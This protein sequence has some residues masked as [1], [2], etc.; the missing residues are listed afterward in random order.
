MKP[1]LAV[2]CLAACS[3]FTADAAVAEDWPVF[4]QNNRRSAVTA[5]QLKLPLGAVWTRTSTHPPQRAWPPPAGQDVY[6][7]RRNLQATRASDTAF[8]PVVAGGK[9]YYGSSA[10]DTLYCVDAASGAT[11]WTFTTEGPIRLAP[12]VAGGKV[13]VG[14][15]DGR[16]TCLDAATGRLVWKVRGGPEDHRLPGNGRIISRWPVRCGML[17]ADDIVYFGAGVFPSQG[18]Y[19][20]AVKAGTGETIW[21][22]KIGTTIEGHLLA[23]DKE[24]YVL[25]GRVGAELYNRATGKRLAGLPASGS[26]FA[27]LA[28]GQFASG[29]SEAG[30]ITRLD[31]RTRK[32]VNVGGR[33]MLLHGGKVYVHAPGSLRQ[34]GGWRVKSGD[35][36]SLAMAGGVLIAGGANEVAAYNA[37]DG[38]RLWAGKADGNVHGLAVA[39]GQL[40][41]STDKGAIHCFGAGGKP[42]KT[43]SDIKKI[44]APYPDDELGKQYALAADAI[45]KQAKVAKGYCLVLDCGEGR[46]AYELA[47]RTKWRI[48]GVE[49]DPK[50]V[51]RARGLLRRAGVYGGRVVVHHLPPGELPYQKYFANVITSDAFVREGRVPSVSAAMIHRVLRPDGGTLVLPGPP[52]THRPMQGSRA[53]R[54]TREPAVSNLVSKWLTSDVRRGAALKLQFVVVGVNPQMIAAICRRPRLPGS[55]EWT[56][57]Y[58]NTANTACSNDDDGR[59]PLALQWFGR[60]GPRR[61]V[62]RHNRTTSPVTSAGRMFV[63]GL[64]HIVAAD[65]Y[66]GTILWRRDVPDSI[67]LAVSKDCGSLA[68]TP[69]T[70]YLASGARCIGLDAETGEQ[71]TTMDVP[72]RMPKVVFDW[73]Y[74][75]CSGDQLFG[76]A[77]VRLPARRVQTNSSWT[78]GYLDRSEIG[79]S[80]ALFSFDR[81][82]GQQQWAYTPKTGVIVN[83][84]IA[85]AEGR[86]YFVESIN[87]ET[88]KAPRDRIPLAALLGKGADVVAVDARTGRTVWRTSV[89]LTA[90]QHT[91]FLAHA[92]GTLVISGSKNAGGGKMRYDL[93]ALDAATGKQRWATTPEMNGRTGG[94]HGEQDQHPAIVG[95][96]IYYKT[97]AVDLKT[98]QRVTAWKPQGGGCSTVTASAHSMFFRSGNPIITDLATGKAQRMTIASRPGC[99]INIIPA[100]GLVLVPEASSGCT[101][102]YPIQTSLAMARVSC[103][104]PKIETKSLSAETAAVTITHSPNDVVIRYTTDGSL[105]TTKAAVYERP[106]ELAY[107]VTVRA[108]AFAADGEKSVAVE[109]ALKPPKTKK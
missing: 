77:A 51:K 91:I 18:V 60:P 19:L 37:A 43:V 15:D 20:C 29:P 103:A 70:V 22:Q 45:A 79:C 71:K 98:G 53:T 72:T 95:D 83:P 54:R 8:H 68:A 38:K 6:H 99:W 21:R 44:E 104:A 69:D 62:D 49:S 4:R 67:R 101:C 100:G 11:L 94:S 10:D 47:K 39:N 31:V 90:L 7:N 9:L 96:V 52:M 3:L 107:G 5:G 84:T 13:Y 93:L 41:A 75:A 55:G 36:F 108:R 106:L 81:R 92:K 26:A 74:V 23:T 59:G 85:I 87:P 27:L 50:K 66:N 46:L 16:V 64:N 80:Y 105:P 73:G 34:D 109:L 42:A 65:A 40:F 35:I 102:G 33:R 56:H 78:W 89:D 63:S 1:H 32:P 25:T 17:V 97:F 24:L 48:V 2:L 12:A 58:A 86:V 57:L 30:H 76:T 88:H 61:M 28:D 14:S 82:K